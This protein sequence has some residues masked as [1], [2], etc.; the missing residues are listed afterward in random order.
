MM[1]IGN[2]TSP[3]LVLPPN[4]TEGNVVIPAGVHVVNLNG[5]GIFWVDFWNEIPED[6]NMDGVVDVID[7][8]AVISAWSI[9]M[10]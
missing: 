1:P 6:I 3:T 5:F 2:V 7:L 9:P 8:L 4:G 10:P